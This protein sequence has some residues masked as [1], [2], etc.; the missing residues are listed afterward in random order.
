MR[1][2]NWI[3]LFPLVLIA[4]SFAVSNRGDIT[5]TLWPLPFAV[6]LPIVFF[7]FL[8]ILVGFLL[9]G[10]ASWKGGQNSRKVARENKKKAND[11]DREVRSLKVEQENQ[12]ETQNLLLKKETT[13]VSTEVK[14]SKWT[15]SN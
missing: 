14:A 11:L 4:L 9:G 2:I 3:L 10:F 8:M 6:D 1:L 5:L 7:G 13:E 15:A 12:Q